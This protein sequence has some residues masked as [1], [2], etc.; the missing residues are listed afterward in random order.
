MM[1]IKNE[2]R[3]IARSIA[4]I[5]PLCD[6][7]FILDDH[8]TDDTVAI[9]RLFQQVTLFESPHTVLN[10]AADKNFLLEKVLAEASPD[11]IVAIDGDEMLAPGTQELLREA[12]QGPSS[13]LSLRILYLWDSETQVRVDGLYGDFHRESVFRPNGSRFE[14]NGNGGNF[15]CG[16]VPWA[17]RQKRRVL[18]IPLLHFGYMLREDRLRK[19]EWYRAPDKYPVPEG[20]DGYRHMVIGDV[21][22]ATYKSRHAGP[23]QLRPLTV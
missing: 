5:L 1:R 8:S 17:N 14:S 16:N 21:F 12:M 11:W 15:H 19:Y 20:E 7:V 18:S 13:C 6:R 23:L 2:A 10:E 4:S 22:P 9:C 3:W